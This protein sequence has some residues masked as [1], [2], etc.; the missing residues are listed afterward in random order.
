MIKNS[1][2][3][4]TSQETNLTQKHNFLLG[5]LVPGLDVEPSTIAPLLHLAHF[6]TR[7]SNKRPSHL[8][9]DHRGILAESE[10]ERLSMVGMVYVT[11]RSDRRWQ[12]YHLARS[13]AFWLCD[14][15]LEVRTQAQINTWVVSLPT[16]PSSF[17]GCGHVLHP[18]PARSQR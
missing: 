9:R 8:G 1:P 13:A 7:S 3:L 2:Q 18:S 5:A 12:G 6:G 10:H 15:T 4:I 14:G 16:D 17:P 11:A